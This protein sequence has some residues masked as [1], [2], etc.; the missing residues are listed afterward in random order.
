MNNLP[1]QQ[2]LAPSAP[3][4]YYGMNVKTGEKIDGKRTVYRRAYATGSGSS[5]VCL[6]PFFSNYKPFLS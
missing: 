1:M 4:L 5:T 6:D 2:L 3:N